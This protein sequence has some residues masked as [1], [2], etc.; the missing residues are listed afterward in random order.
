MTAGAKHAKRRRLDQHAEGAVTVN[1]P[2]H[3]LD[4]ALVTR[5]RVGVAATVS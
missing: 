4:R 2:D 1:P 3:F 5:F